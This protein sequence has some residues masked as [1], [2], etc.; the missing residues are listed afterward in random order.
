M[1]WLSSLGWWHVVLSRDTRSF[2]LPLREVEL[3][4]TRGSMYDLFYRLGS[5]IQPRNLNAI[6]GLGIFSP[7]IAV[8]PILFPVCRCQISRLM[9]WW[10]VF[11]FIRTRATVGRDKRLIVLCKVLYASLIEPFKLCVWLILILPVVSV[12]LGHLLLEG[13]FPAISTHG[14]CQ[15]RRS[16]LSLLRQVLHSML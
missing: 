8:E 5:L 4:A 16:R 2:P 6:W 7:T 1:W 15:I 3:E 14:S 12:G 9:N 13:T 10:D 11:G